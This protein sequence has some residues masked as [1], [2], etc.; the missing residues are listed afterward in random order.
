MLAESLSILR[1]VHAVAPDILVGVSGG[2]DSLVVLDLCLRVWEKH[3]VHPFFLYF[4]PGLECE[5][6]HV[7]AAEKRHGITV[8]RLQHPAMASYL[9]SSHLRT[10]NVAVE[11]AFTRNIDWSDVEAVL[12]SRT[13]AKWI[14]G[15]HR[16]TDSL[17]RRGMLT[18]TGGVV[19][20]S[21]KVYPIYK[22]APRD[23]VAY[24][25]TRRIPIPPVI[26]SRITGTGGLNPSKPECLAWLCEHYPEDYRKIVAV[27][28]KAPLLIERD[29]LR[30]KYGIEAEVQWRKREKPRRGGVPQGEAK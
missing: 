12:R 17:Q 28:D 29:K 30:V 19:E 13:N 22:W 1:R 8:T 9:R 7:R 16:M 26:G 25:R 5:E 4:L 3:R 14:A 10:C 21:H 20:K 2:K 18:G 27:F 6:R 11:N 24:L 15:G 23:V